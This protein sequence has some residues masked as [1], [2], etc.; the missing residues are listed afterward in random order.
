ME[1]AAARGKGLGGKLGGTSFPLDSWISYA[2]MG[3]GQPQLLAHGRLPSRPHGAWPDA[4]LPKIL[5]PAGASVPKRARRGARDRAS[6]QG[7]SQFFA[8]LAQRGKQA[9]SDG[10]VWPHRPANRQAQ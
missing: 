4:L 7:L 5:E 6:A 1:L 3:R 10:Y 2:G 8:T 9:G